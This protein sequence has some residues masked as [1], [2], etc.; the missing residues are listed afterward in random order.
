M[1]LK[2]F[3]TQGRRTRVLC[4]NTVLKNDGQSSLVVR[5]PEDQQALDKQIVHKATAA[6]SHS[7]PIRKTKASSNS[8]N[9]FLLS[10]TPLMSLPLC[11]VVFKLSSQYLPHCLLCVCAFSVFCNAECNMGISL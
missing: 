4:K 10:F 5:Q 2:Q 9:L 11:L 1:V 8:F 3:Y 6:A 7:S